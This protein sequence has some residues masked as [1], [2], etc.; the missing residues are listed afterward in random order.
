MTSKLRLYVSL[1]A[2]GFAGS[3]SVHAADETVSAV[4]PS[5]PATDSAGKKGGGDKRLQAALEQRLKQLD[6]T[7]QLTDDQKLK[8]KDIWAKQRDELKSLPA[9][10]KR[11]KGMDALKA[12]RDQVRA[13]LTPSQQAKFDSMPAEGRPGK[14]KGKK[15][16]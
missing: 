4:L 12:S 1:I 3:A 8:I 11:T 5:E 7:L 16:L 10:E 2:L 6:E 15:A 9:G 14:I 13:V